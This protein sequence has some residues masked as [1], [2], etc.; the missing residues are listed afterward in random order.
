MEGRKNMNKKKQ[1]IAFKMSA[2]RAGLG[3]IALLMGAL[4][5]AAVATISSYNKN[6]STNIQQYEKDA[7]EDSSQECL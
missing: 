4:N 3:L 2:I 7:Q 1:S 5:V 6:L